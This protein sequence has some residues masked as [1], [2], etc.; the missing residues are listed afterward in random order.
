MCSS[1]PENF[2]PVHFLAPEAEQHKWR[3]RGLP[4]GSNRLA[5]ENTAVLF[6]SEQIPF[7]VD[8]TGTIGPFLVRFYQAEGNKQS[9]VELIKANQ[10][11]FLTQLELAVRFGKT[12]I[13]DEVC[14]QNFSRALNDQQ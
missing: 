7:V 9:Q 1:L 14:S 2:D 12:L 5:I 11:D 3:N 6:R 8:P 10:V 13:V 4:S